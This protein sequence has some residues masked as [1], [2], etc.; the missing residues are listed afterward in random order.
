MTTS[1]I[2]LRHFCSHGIVQI[3]RAC[4]NVAIGNAVQAAVPQSA[5]ASKV[6]RPWSRDAERASRLR[7]KVYRPD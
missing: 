2:A 6:F 4:A 1:V 5:F 3:D 7:G